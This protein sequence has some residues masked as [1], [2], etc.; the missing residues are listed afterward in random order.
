MLHPRHTLHLG[1]ALLATGCTD[2]APVE[3]NSAVLITLDTTN[4][5]TLGCYGRRAG[6]TPHLDHL[7]E[8]SLVYTNARSVA[9]L[10]LPSHASMLTGLYP[11]RHTVRDNGLT[12][13][14]GSAETLAERASASGYQTAA[15]VASVVLASPYGLAQGFELYDEPETTE[16]SGTGHLLERNADEVTRAA[17]RWLAA[18][19]RT[20]PFF[21]WVH[22]FDPHAPYEPAPAYLERV[23]AQVGVRFPDYLAEV[24]QA[25]TSIGELVAALEREHSLARTFVAVVADHGESLYRHEEPTHS[26]LVYDATIAVPMFLRYPDGYRAGERSA[27]VVS[28]VDLFPTFLEALDLAPPAEV[29]GRSL[30]R[31]PV[32]RDRGVYFESFYGFL[33]F[34]WSP[35]VGWA[36]EQGTY[37]HSSSPELFTAGDTAQADDQLL[38]ATEEAARLALRAQESIR[39]TTSRPALDTGDAVVDQAM[40]EQLKA[41]GYVAI[42]ELDQELPDPLETEGL[43]APRGHVRE[44]IAFYDATLLATGGEVDAGIERLRELLRD[45]PGN[46]IAAD[47]LASLLNQEQRYGETIELLAPLRRAGALRRGSLG[48]LAQALERRG[49][50]PARALEVYLEAHQLLPGDEVIVEGVVRM[51]RELGRDEEA[52][53]FEASLR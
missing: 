5:G 17:V 43:P 44:M 35:L 23:R 25:D 42:G 34:G 18:R 2:S 50:E 52:R 39:R 19:D 24:A 3:R 30:Y 41:L 6:I 11:P 9:P 49:G 48:I 4:P 22:Y 36:D 8:Q 46:R 53:A 32:P 33:N 40:R 51:L 12:P 45:E 26:L 7:A 38:A 27:E 14:P 1:L 28:V 15:F 16:T 29:D 31:R 21:L 37:I 10:T 47:M 13:L 20:R